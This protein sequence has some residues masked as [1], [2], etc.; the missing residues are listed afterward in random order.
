VL[1]KVAAGAL[2]AKGNDTQSCQAEHVVPQEGILQYGDGTS[3]RA[4]DGQYVDRPKN[5]DETKT[6]VGKRPIIVGNLDEK[7][8]Y[9][10]R[11]QA[12]ESRWDP[13][14][15]VAGTPPG[16][17]PGRGQRV[18]DCLLY[19]HICFIFELCNYC[20]SLSEGYSRI[21]NAAF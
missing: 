7:C 11:E 12:P 13:R 2:V 19:F 17:A 8:E 5:E 16:G 14:E 18:F 10:E 6:F 21:K 3:S 15:P 9:H 20:Q 4:L 1:G